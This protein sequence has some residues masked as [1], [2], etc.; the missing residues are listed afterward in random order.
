MQTYC[1]NSPTRALDGEPA[2]DALTDLDQ[3]AADLGTTAR[4]GFQP[5][6]RTWPPQKA[7]AERCVQRLVT[8]VSQEGR[9]ILGRTVHQAK[10]LEWPNVLFLDP[11]LIT[12]AGWKNV[13][14]TAGLRRSGPTCEPA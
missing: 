11:S 3:D 4:D 9:P 8:V 7:T 14:S 6:G 5:D 13:M 2:P 12:T 1:A 10:G